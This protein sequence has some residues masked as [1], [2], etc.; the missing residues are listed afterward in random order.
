[1][2]NF[3][4][5]RTLTWALVLWTGYIATWTVLTGSGP[6]IV[7]LWWLVGLVVFGLLWFATPQ[8]RRGRRLEGRFVWPGSTPGLVSIPADTATGATALRAWEDEGVATLTTDG[9]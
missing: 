3:L 5:W 8:A 4:R 6:T 9:P 7:T 1:M 2:T